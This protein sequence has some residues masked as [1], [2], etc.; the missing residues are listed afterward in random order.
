MNQPTERIAGPK[1]NLRAARILCVAL[2]SGI[3]LFAAIISILCLTNGPVMDKTEQRYNDIILYIAAGLA[4]ACLIGA[5]A[6]YTKKIA[7][8]KNS[9]VSLIDKLN[10][11]R[12][13]LIVYMAPCE[14][15]ALLSMAL[16]FLTGNLLLLI[17]TAMLLLAMS[18]KFPFTKKVIDELNL[19]WKEQADLN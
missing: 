5:R 12:S 2:M 13:A 9:Q 14:G 15:A 17:I 6:M 3:T 16:L 7:G 11:Y 4:L 18:S 8:I 10:Q 19:D 1:E